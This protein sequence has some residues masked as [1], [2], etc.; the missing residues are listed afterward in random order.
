[1]ADP[2]APTSEP[3]PAPSAP[4][5]AAPPPASA[6]AAPPPS[7]AAAAASDGDD[8]LESLRAEVIKFDHE[9]RNTPSE[10]AE[11]AGTTPAAT[12][13][14]STPPVAPAAPTTT[15]FE[16]LLKRYGTPEKAEAEFF[17]L[18]QRISAMSKELKEAKANPS[19]SAPST[20]SAPAATDAPPSPAAAPSAAAP[21]A[22][23]APP[24]P[25]AQPAAPAVPIEEQAFKHAVEV[26]PRS[27]DLI[28]SYNRDTAR[29]KEIDTEIP[30]LKEAITNAKALIAHPQVD[31]MLK[32]EQRDVLSRAENVLAAREATRSKLQLDIDRN[33]LAFKN[34]VGEHAQRLQAEEAERAREAQED[35]DADKKAGEF[36]QQWPSAFEQ[37]FVKQG[38]DAEM[39]EAA[40]DYAKTVAL[41][42]PGRIDLADL[43]AFMAQ[44]LKA[45]GEQIDRHHRLQARK[46]ALQKTADTTTVPTTPTAPTAPAPAPVDD[47]DPLAAMRL[48]TRA[49]FREQR[50]K[51]NAR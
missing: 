8:P 45:Y 9:R 46:Y 33:D 17:A 38:L 48:Q 2:V 22:Q 35:A 30:T 12:P 20:P 14:G 18:E 27:R 34:I 24:Q 37:E 4:A 43:P 1:M 21:P 31:E 28:A 11:P 40:H 50:Q 29:L 47:D 51:A 13:E 10:P 23:P 36:V 15:P 41:A 7:A 16:S 39:R 6:P 19:P 32:A 25:P 44:T 49:A 3:A 26:D 42:R 5:P